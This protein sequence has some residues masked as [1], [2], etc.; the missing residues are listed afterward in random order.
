M[1][2]F[3]KSDILL[4][5]VKHQPVLAYKIGIIDHLSLHDLLQMSP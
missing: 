4:Q 5:G 3:V 1:P 2:S